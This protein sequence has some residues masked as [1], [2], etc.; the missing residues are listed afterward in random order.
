MSEIGHF[1]VFGV[2]AAAVGAAIA[3]LLMNRLLERARQQIVRLR[4]DLVR[5]RAGW[6]PASHAQPRDKRNGNGSRA[7]A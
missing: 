5:G 2:A 4:R 3:F 7:S 1:V 6:R